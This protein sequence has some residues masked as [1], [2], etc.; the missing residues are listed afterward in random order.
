MDK[1]SHHWRHAM[2]SNPGW[3][4]I[5]VLVCEVFLT[6][7]QQLRWFSFNAHKGWTVL[8]A[9][10]C[11]GALFVVLLLWWIAA[12]LFRWQFQFSI[13][14]VLMLFVVV[15]VPL[16]WFT[17]EKK[18]AKRQ[19]EAMEWIRTRHGGS[20]YDW[21]C[22]ADGRCGRGQN[23]PPVTGWLRDSLGDD[24]FADVVWV[25]FADGYP[26][27]PADELEHLACLPHIKWLEFVATFITDAGLKHLE[28]I[29]ELRYLKLCYND[30]TDAGLKALGGLAELQ[31]LLLDNN[32]ISGPGLE[33]L[34]KLTKLRTLSLK[35][36][37]ITGLKGIDGLTQLEILDLRETQ[38]T[39]ADLKCISNLIGLQYLLLS[40]TRVTGN[41]LKHLARMTQLKVLYLDGTDV[42]DAGFEH[43]EELTQLHTLN[44]AKT[45]ITDVG[46]EHL[47]ALRQLRWLEVGDTRTTLSKWEEL[48]ADLPP[49]CTIK[50]RYNTL[51]GAENSGGPIQGQRLDT[52]DVNENQ[53]SRDDG[54]VRHDGQPD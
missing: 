31:V 46:I 3:L 49:Q 28:G 18:A 54:T 51:S 19:A 16:S 20:R 34:K 53:P 39:D 8:I 17:T 44:V 30:I 21:E 4:I 23:T 9:I 52:T 38:V 40:E 10:A 47:K 7:S 27:I 26:Q 14:S 36:M 5:V 32:K 12:M 50:G 6:L 2:R 11:M 1:I 43:I 37:P 29:K 48:S 13:R 22:D 41:G 25:M 35:Y 33:H 15:A 42:G 24:F 45:Q